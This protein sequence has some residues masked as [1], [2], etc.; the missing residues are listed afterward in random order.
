MSE[1]L[2]VRSSAAA[3]PPHALVKRSPLVHASQSSSGMSVSKRCKVKR[4]CKK[5]LGRKWDKEGKKCMEKNNN[6]GNSHRKPCPKKGW[7]R[8]KKGKCKKPKKGGK[9][10]SGKK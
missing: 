6:G 1:C 3:A 10:K 9:N 7:I 4:C 8:N 2:N 5:R